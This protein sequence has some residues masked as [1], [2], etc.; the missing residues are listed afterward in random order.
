[1]VQKKWGFKKVGRL[2]YFFGGLLLSSF[3]FFFFCLYQISSSDNKVQQA[4]QTWDQA[5]DHINSGKSAVSLPDHLM[6]KVSLPVIDLELPVVKGVSDI[7]LQQGVGHDP[8]TAMPGENGNTVLAGH[9]DGVF[10][11]L[12]EMK[13]GDEII[14]QTITGTFYYEMVSHKIVDKNDLHAVQPSQEPRLP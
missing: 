13:K 11:R 1:M 10:R 8:I 14:V 12:G 6:G 4:V 7:D 5:I 9:R 2:I 3:S